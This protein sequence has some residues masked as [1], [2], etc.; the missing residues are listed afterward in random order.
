M[1]R[2]SAACLAI[3]ATTAVAL[4]AHAELSAEAARAAVA[5]FYKA[6][7]AENAKDVPELVKQSTTSEWVSCRTNE[8][9]NTRD[10]VIGGIGMRLK[11]VPDLKWEIKDVLVSGNQVTVR[12]EATGTPAG[13]FMGAP[14]TGK[15][16]KL[17]SIDVHT[18]EGGK[19]VRSYHIEDW[20][21]AVRQLSAAKYARRPQMSFRVRIFD[22]PRNDSSQLRRV[23]S[24]AGLDDL[25]GVLHGFAALDLVD[26][27][28]AVGHLAPDG[29]LAVEEGRI[30][31]ANEELA[32][33]GIR[34][35]GARHRGRAADMRFLV[36]LS[37]E[38]LARAAG[39]GALRA[40]GLRHETL[41]HAME[42]DA[43]VKPLAHQ[44]L[45]TSDMARRQIGAHFD[46]DGTLGGF[47][48]QSIFCISHALFSSGL[49]GRLRVLK[50]TA[51]GRPATAPPSPSVNGNGVQRCNVSITAIRYAIRSSSPA[52]AVS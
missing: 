28:H 5:P 14:H 2:I 19:M 8:I 16:F 13:E 23:S 10:E 34:T 40:S 51:K 24:H 27:L 38:F 11:G 46:G 41:D 3:A 33:A 35:G 45:D 18:L 49:G 52:F 32:V 15:S 25:V 20:L 9:C 4:P 42:H 39:T 21:G 47:K 29:V 31:E 48:N 43:I 36:E 12:G 44:F 22:A 7:N 30:V 26:V 17:M 37:L 1:K 50:V 6:L